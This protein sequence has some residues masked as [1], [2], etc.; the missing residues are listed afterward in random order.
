MSVTFCAGMMSDVSSQATLPSTSVSVIVMRERPLRAVERQHPGAHELRG[1]GGR[2]R[3][4]CA[5]S[6]RA[7]RSA[8]QSDDDGDGR[9]MSTHDQLLLSSPAPPAS[10]ARSSAGSVAADGFST[11]TRI[12]PS[13]TAGS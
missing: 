13:V 11:P 8:A 9:E 12:L 6:A 5:R 1:V 2:Q 3:R 10:S 7:G 4:G